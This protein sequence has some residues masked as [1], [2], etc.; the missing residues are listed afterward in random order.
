MIYQK[1]LKFKFNVSD[2]YRGFPNFFI[3]NYIK[4]NKSIDNHDVLNFLKK[5]IRSEYIEM[6]KKIKK[7]YEKIEYLIF[8]HNF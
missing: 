7:S 8:F 5:K 1:I 6:I 2:Y 4:K 3:S